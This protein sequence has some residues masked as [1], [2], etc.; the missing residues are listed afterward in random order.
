MPTASVSA[1]FPG[2]ANGRRENF[3]PGVGVKLPI[4]RFQERRVLRSWISPRSYCGQYYYV[5]ISLHGV[6]GNESI[7]DRFGLSIRASIH[8]CRTAGLDGA[9]ICIFDHDSFA[10][11]VAYP[12]GRKW[13][14]SAERK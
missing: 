14:D 1:A 11:D 3:P 2:T 9:L 7:V 13:F 10:R 5:L 4:A 12:G 6:T 8:L